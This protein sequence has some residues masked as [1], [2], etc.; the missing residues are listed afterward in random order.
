MQ[1]YSEQEANFSQ[2]KGDIDLLPINIATPDLA[3]QK[4]NQLA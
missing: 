1:Y 2:T 4:V 3:T